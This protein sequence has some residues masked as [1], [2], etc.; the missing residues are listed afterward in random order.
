MHGVVLIIVMVITGGAIA[1]IGDKLG[2]KIGKKRLSIFGLR[3]RHTSIIITIITGILITGLSI[4]AMAFVSKDVRTALFGL[5]ELNAAMTE[6][7][8][9]LD[10]SMLELMDTQRESKFTQEELETARA[11]IT[12]L[13]DEQQ[14]LEKESQRLREGNERLEIEKADLTSQ[15]ENLS[16]INENLTNAN[17]N[18]SSANSKLESTNKELSEFNITL[19]ADN[20]KL[21]QDNAA[22]EERAKNLRDGLIAIR[23]GDIVFR[24][25]E[26][27]ASAVIN[28]NRTADEVAAD[29]NKLASLASRSITERFGEEIDSSLWIYQPEFQRAVE[30]ISNSQKNMAVRISAAGNLVKGEPIRTSLSLYPNEEIYSEGEYIFSKEYEINSAE[31]AENI[32][33]QFLTEINHS[34]VEAGILPDPI[35][36]NVGVIDSEQLYKLLEKLENTRGKIKLT[37]RARENVY[38]I[39]PL[40]LNI[41]VE[42]KGKK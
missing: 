38:S 34:A 4:G 25:G 30:T 5:E 28:G 22:L 37:A 3:P 23:E 21:S 32:V 6:T 29:L 15:N 7:R 8:A 40:R 33:R 31:D 17:E 14:E 39:G 42:Q 16:G 19:T 26:V 41:K 20:E 18:L 9:A 13:K 35:T 12:K 1:F 11:E 27:L 10:A 24:A 36:G 2:T